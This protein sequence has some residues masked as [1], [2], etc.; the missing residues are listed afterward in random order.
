MT[1]GPA[2]G[3]GSVVTAGSG[4]MSS[5]QYRVSCPCVHDIGYRWK[6]SRYTSDIPFVVPITV[7]SGY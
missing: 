7:K 2:A 6:L 4:V 3:T 5:L 1:A